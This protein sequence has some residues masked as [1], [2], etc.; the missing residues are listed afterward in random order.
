MVADLLVRQRS[1]ALA[2]RCSVAF[3]S[4][5][6]QLPSSYVAAQ[7]VSVGCQALSRMSP[8]LQ[9]CVASNWKSAL[10]KL[11]ATAHIPP[12]GATADDVKT[13]SSPKY[14]DREP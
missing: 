7:A 8:T 10:A 4:S 6:S 3:V 13:P 2:V 14:M 11:Q 5:F 12:R 9:P 1:A